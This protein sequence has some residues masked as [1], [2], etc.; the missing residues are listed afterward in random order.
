MLFSS[1]M[2]NAGPALFP[3]EDIQGGMGSLPCICFVDL[4]KV[5]TRVPCVSCGVVSGVWGYQVYNCSRSVAL[6]AGNKSDSFPV[7]LLLTEFLGAD[8]GLRVSPSLIS[9]SR[10]CILRM[11]WFCSCHQVVTSSSH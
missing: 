10:V 9:G 7:G 6:I 5:V 11:M 3:P 4:E 8:T 2:W 1:W